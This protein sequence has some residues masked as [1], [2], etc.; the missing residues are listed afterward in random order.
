M[1][2]RPDDYICSVCGML[3]TPIHLP[4]RDEWRP[5]ECP[6]CA[7]HARADAEL[8]T[9]L[10]NIEAQIDGIDD[11][12][13]RLG[14][15]RRHV[16]AT[17]N[18]F[19]PAYRTLHTE[20]NGL[21]VFGPRGT[22][23]T[24]LMSAIMRAMILDHLHTALAEKKFPSP[25][26]FPR[27]VSTTDLLREIRATFGNRDRR[28]ES[29]SSIIERYGR[30]PVLILDDLGAE[31]VTDWTLTILYSLIDRRYRDMR[32]TFVTSNLSL[33]DLSAQTSDRITSR[34]AEMCRVVRISGPDR[35]LKKN[36]L[37]DAM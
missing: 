33:A 12:L 20:G 15:A 16:H 9:M 19:G 21:F 35:R 6:A 24:H 11:I 14:V 1:T 10:A 29:E 30:Y 23:K 5:R 7:S 36:N 3:V 32:R 27:M 37:K 18:D 25:H 4:F 28:A 26:E 17:V 31:Q 34:L 13:M 2:T 8:R 22:G